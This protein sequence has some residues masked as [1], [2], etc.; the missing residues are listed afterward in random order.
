MSLRERYESG[1]YASTSNSNQQQGRGVHSD[2][3][4]LVSN[5]GFV[6]VF[7]RREG[8]KITWL[9]RC[10]KPG[11]M[12]SGFSFPH[13]FLVAGQDP[14]CPASSHDSA[15]V[16]PIQRSESPIGAGVREYIPNEFTG[17]RERA[18]AAERAAELKSLEEN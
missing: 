4:G 17:P 18:A 2:F 6:T 8:R 11:C 16:E 10:S 13:E 9:A 1:Q 12:S 15:T 5:D 14:K 7:A 3:T